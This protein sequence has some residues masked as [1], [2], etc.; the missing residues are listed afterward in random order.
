MESE[1]AVDAEVEVGA[2]VG[3]GSPFVHH[4]DGQ[5][6]PHMQVML[7]GRH[8]LELDTSFYYIL[9]SAHRSTWTTRTGASR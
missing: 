4:A 2:E 5:S 8:E 3:S 9:L 1:V 6:D 7:L